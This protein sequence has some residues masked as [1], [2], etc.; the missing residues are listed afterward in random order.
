M[1]AVVRTIFGSPDVLKI[2]E[3]EKPV[4]ADDEVLVK[5]CAASVNPLDWRILRGSPFIIRLMGMGL[6]K[7][8]HRILGADIAGRVEAVGKDVMDL[9]PGDEV[10]GDIENGGFSEYVCA[11]TNLLVPKPTNLPFAEAA[12]IPVAALTALQGLRDEGKISSGQKVLINGASGG[13]GTFAVQLAK[14][15][16]AEVTAVCSTRNLEMVRSIGADH[17]IDYTQEDFVSKNERYDLV[18]V[19]AGKRSL[20]ACRSVLKPD[21]TLVMIGSSSVPQMFAAM[22]LGPLVS[23]VGK[24][25]IRSLMAMANRDD[26]VM[27]KELAEAG[28]LKPVIDRS[29]TLQEV[30]EALRYLEAG[31][32]RGKVV[33]TLEQA[34]TN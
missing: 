32:A 18:V 12:A 11:K 30:P 29:C 28:K 33:I 5:V 21:G 20:F 19:L 10:F 1:Q 25:K 24:K 27:V 22:L 16:G 9:K 6:F 23:L 17:V 13:V 31:H 34:G 2:R 8:R 7:P 15:Y 4:P 14:W 26:L 3:T